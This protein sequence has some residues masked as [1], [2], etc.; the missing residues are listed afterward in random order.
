MENKEFILKRLR[1][2]RDDCNPENVGRL[3]TEALDVAGRAD[4]N[5]LLS[6]IERINGILNHT[7]LRAIEILRE[8]TK[9]T[10]PSDIAEYMSHFDSILPRFGEERG[11]AYGILTITAATY[12]RLV[13]LISIIESAEEN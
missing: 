10:T 12:H 3:M 1:D 6:R 2:F 7:R 13:G 11:F 9:P 8:A 5:K 4:L